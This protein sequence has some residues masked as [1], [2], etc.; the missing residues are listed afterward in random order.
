S[1]SS[2]WNVAYADENP[3]YFCPSS[4]LQECEVNGLTTKHVIMRI[5]ED[6]RTLPPNSPPIDGMPNPICQDVDG[7]FLRGMKRVM[8]PFGAGSVE[9]RMRVNINKNTP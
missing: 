8:H 3:A 9:G 2:L 6:S 5:L 4:A 7:D 1:V